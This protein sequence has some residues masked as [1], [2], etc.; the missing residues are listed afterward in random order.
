MWLEKTIILLLF[1]NLSNIFRFYLVVL[2]LYN[3]QVCLT[4]IPN[5]LDLLY[6]FLFISKLSFLMI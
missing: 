3:S 4:G 1:P 2:N 6:I 5:S